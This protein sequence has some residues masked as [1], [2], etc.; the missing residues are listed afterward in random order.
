MKRLICLIALIMAM[1][2]KSAAQE[3]SGFSLSVN[4]GGWPLV[5]DIIFGGI[6]LSWVP[7]LERPTLGSIY[8]DAYSD[9]KSTGAM[10]VI[11]D[12][13]VKKWLSVPLTLSTNLLWQNHSSILTNDTHCDIDGTVQLMSGIRFKYLNRP[14][15]NFYS[16]VNLGLCVITDSHHTSITVNGE[17]TVKYKKDYDLIPAVQIVP[18]GLRFGGK[19]YGTA[20][21]G[22]GTQYFGGMVGIGVRL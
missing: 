8:R 12:L 11:G 3:D 1:S 19:I 17:T 18:F 5:E 20:E 2:V 10:A 16:S 9:M 14:R 15:F 6:G 7:A 21:I 13:P 4:L 22:L